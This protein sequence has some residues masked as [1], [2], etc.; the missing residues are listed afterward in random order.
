MGLAAIA[1]LCLLM[2]ASGNIVYSATFDN[3]DGE[4]PNWQYW[5]DDYG[6]GIVAPQK[7]VVFS[8]HKSMLITSPRDHATKA[9]AKTP[10]LPAGY[11]DKPYVLEV[12]FYLP[13]T[14]NHWFYV[15]YNSHIVCT[16][17]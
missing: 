12:S 15:M 10:D 7:N 2:N 11:G 16:V 5:V 14:N 8:T 13:D 9:W 4:L 3:D 17:D 6:N 1:V